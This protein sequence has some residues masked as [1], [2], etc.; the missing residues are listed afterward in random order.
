ML[1]VIGIRRNMDASLFCLLCN[2]G[3]RPRQLLLMSSTKICSTFEIFLNCQNR[4][5]LKEL[6]IHSNDA[7]ALA[8]KEIVK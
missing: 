2:L 7:L 1:F 8:G 5:K 6:Y 4:C 3:W